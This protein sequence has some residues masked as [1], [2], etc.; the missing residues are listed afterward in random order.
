MCY[1]RMLC[2]LGF[3]QG[4]LGRADVLAISGVS[5]HCAYLGGLGKQILLLFARA[6]AHFGKRLG[7]QIVSLFLVLPAHFAYLGTGFGSRYCCY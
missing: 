3:C 2:A 1:L 4:V 7:K 5:A 6:S